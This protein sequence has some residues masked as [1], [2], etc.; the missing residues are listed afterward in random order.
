ME[1]VLVIN[2]G[3]SSVK[4]SV[5]DREKNK[6]TRIINARAV[7][8]FH[9]EAQIN[10]YDANNNL[11]IDK[12]LSEIT[13][14]LPNHKVAIEFFL[15]WLSQQVN[16]K[17]VAV[18]HRIVHGGPKYSKPVLITD[19]VNEDLHS[20][21]PL[22]PLHQQHNLAPVEI[23]KNLYPDLLQIACFDT[24]FH[25]SMPGVAKRFALPKQYY[26]DGIRRYG[27]HGLS[28][29]YI[30]ER[31]N[32]QQ[33][34]DGKK[35]IIAHLG[36]G[37]SLCAV[38]NKKSIATTMSFTP[39]DGLVMGTRCGDLD[40]GVVLHLMSHYSMSAEDISDLLYKESGLRGV[41]NESNNMRTLL[42]SSLHASVQ[43]VELFCY[44]VNRH[45]GA[46]VAELGGVDQIVFTA[47][48][49][50]NSPVIREKICMLAKWLGIALDQQANER[51]QATISNPE[52]SVEI[53]VIPTNEALMIAKHVL[54]I[55]K[56]S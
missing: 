56:N 29:E 11:L 40:P 12:K 24:A 37:A 50:E 31:I 41:S 36:N 16:I 44:Q 23:V 54:K 9:E 21:Q 45:I 51:G 20:Y 33:I 38:A 32:K 10:I 30:V 3:S 8:L 49:G 52:S 22:A 14:D 34:I 13:V 48:I 18:G 26:D 19:E 39:L 46:L 4:L 35:I 1:N 43:A 15:D 2:A 27:F 28:Y 7:R 5:F 47:G 6:L 53:S 25:Q 17:L 55:Y 42:A